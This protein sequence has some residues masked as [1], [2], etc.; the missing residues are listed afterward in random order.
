MDWRESLLRHCGPGVLCGITLR[1]WLGLLRKEGAQ[2]D[3]SR[4]PRVAAITLQSLKAGLFG[5]VERSRYDSL[6]QK[7]TIQ[8]PLFVLGHWRS[9]TTHL[10][11]LISQDARF[12]FPNT[13][14]VSFPHI[15]L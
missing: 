1:D 9:G 2:I 8:P 5:F 14:Q 6:L 7:V 3:L 11:Q 10:H 12:A 4:L 13:Y 15:F